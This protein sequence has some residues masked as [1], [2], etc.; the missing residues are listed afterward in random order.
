MVR[1]VTTSERRGQDGGVLRLAR[2]ALL[3]LAGCA[4]AEDGAADAPG[5]SGNGW[6]GLGGQTGSLMPTCGLAPLAR[7]RG[8]PSSAA[9]IVVYTTACGASADGELG[10]FG[11]DGSPVPVQ[12]QPLGNGAVLIT[13]QNVLPPGNYV[14]GRRA[15][16]ADAGAVELDGGLDADAGIEP[17]GGRDAVAPT[18]QGEPLSVLAPSAPPARLGELHQLGG[19]CGSLLEL[20]LD[21]GIEPYLPSL[22]LDLRVGDAPA[23]R[24]VDFGTLAVSATGTAQIAIPRELLTTGGPYTITLQGVL[25]GDAAAIEPA[26]LEVEC[27][28]VPRAS[29]PDAGDGGGCGVMGGGPPTSTRAPWL[30]ATLAFLRW[31][32]RRRRPPD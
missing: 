5:L 20:A 30:L 26:T 29:M 2:L 7:N 28:Y 24:V 11:A 9:G 23:Q 13:P 32:R 25:A 27:F 4:S 31:R 6:T 15:P 12:T 8:V 22:A 21:P 16:S 1:G 3:V 14:L 18:V 10:L 17:I 19:V